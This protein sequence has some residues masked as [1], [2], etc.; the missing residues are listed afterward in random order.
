MHRMKHCFTVSM[1][2]VISKVSLEIILTTNY[3]FV[4]KVSI[5]W[6]RPQIIND[7][8]KK[9]GFPKWDPK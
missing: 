8:D 4:C 2:M 9:W 5:G 7:E 3:M 1:L 6:P